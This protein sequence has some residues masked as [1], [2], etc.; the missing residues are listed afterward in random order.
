MERYSTLYRIPESQYTPGCPVCIAAGALLKDN[1]TGDILAQLKFKNI[2]SRVIAGLVVAVDAADM[3]GSPLDGVP[4]YSYLDL[5]VTRDEEFG[6]KKAILLPDSNTRRFTARCKKIFF[7]DGGVWEAP[8]D[9]VWAPFGIPD[10]LDSALGQELAEQYRRDTAPSAKYVPT[11]HLDLWSCTCGAINRAEELACHACKL[12]LVE[13]TAAM[14]KDALASGK[15]AYD[16]AEAEKEAALKEADAKQRKKNARVL[17]CIAVTAVVCVAAF[18]L[19]TR[20]VMPAN[21]YKAAEALLAAGDFDEAIIAFESLGDYKDATGRVLEAKYGKADMLF[22]EEKYDDAVSLFVGLK[23]YKDSSG[24]VLESQY[25]IADSLYE[26]GKHEEAQKRFL[27]LGDYADSKERV[28]KIAEE[29]AIAL[30]VNAKAGDSITYGV[31]EQDAKSTN[32]EEPIEWIVLEKKGDLL[33][34]I[35]R[36]ALDCQ[37]YHTKD[38]AVSWESCSIRNWLNNIFFTKAFNENEQQT[39]AAT[40][41]KDENTGKSVADNVFLLSLAEAKKYFSSD[42]LRKVKPTAYAEKSGAYVYAAGDESGMWWLRGPCVYSS[43]F[44]SNKC[45]APV[46]G[47]PGGILSDGHFV[48][49]QDVSVRPAMWIDISKIAE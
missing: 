18:L 12:K 11:I 43:P 24:R 39:I 34:L 13:Q 10:L 44:Y 20:V 30:V 19:V 5:N 3:G 45:Y 29:I 35:S 36:Y 28:E 8:A 48:T 16:S 41:T 22:A 49:G 15:A 32:G 42:S 6:Q 31:Y 25:A 27:E 7:T 2:S 46:V 26:N 4:E 38:I 1:Q 17:G 37:P 33:L 9:A 23:G 47:A 40:N 21:A 14:D